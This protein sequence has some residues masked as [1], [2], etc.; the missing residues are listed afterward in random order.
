MA[1]RLNADIVVT[2]QITKTAGTERHIEYRIDDVKRGEMLSSDKVGWEGTKDIIGAAD[3]LARRIARANG[4]NDQSVPNVAR[5]T[6]SSFEALSWFQLGHDKLLAREL[7]G[8]VTNFENATKIDDKFALAYLHLGR[9]F[10]R[11]GNRDD[12]KEALG[13]AMELRDRA[14]ERDR[15]LIE[16]YYQWLGLNE[17]QKGN[18]SFERMLTKFPG[19]KEALLSLAIINRELR[20]YD[21]SIE[22]GRRATNEDPQFGAAW[23][24]LGYSY[25]FKRDYVNAIHSFSRY[26]EVEPGDTKSFRLAR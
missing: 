20:R 9:A 11:L 18:E 23:N 2:A 13:K 6:T 4:L 14:G 22:F 10:R 21:R 8:A 19:D 1:R 26:A 7:G 24:T 3:V 17:R 12:A 25:L 16:G 5:L 15:M